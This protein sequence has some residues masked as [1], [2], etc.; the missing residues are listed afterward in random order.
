MIKTKIK[1]MI[2][3]IKLIPLKGDDLID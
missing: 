2:K 1:E 3:L